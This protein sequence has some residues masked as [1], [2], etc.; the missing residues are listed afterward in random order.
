VIVFLDIDGVLNSHRW[1]AAK[2]PGEHPESKLIDPASVAMLAPLVDAGV[3]FVLSSTWR[4]WFDGP[5]AT[6]M[7]A[8]A[9][10]RGQVIGRTKRDP[11][12]PGLIV[13]AETRG[14]QVFEWVV[15]H[16]DCGPFVILDD[17]DGPEYWAPVY[18]RLVLTEFEVGLQPEHVE[19]AL[20]MLGVSCT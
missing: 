3:E 1:R 5:A 8:R 4:A 19:R 11:D 10:F 17:D 7:L 13:R 12:G 15:E 2:R 16:P 6:E 20:R 18:D 9:G 14:M